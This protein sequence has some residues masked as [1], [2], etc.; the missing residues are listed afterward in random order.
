MR[1]AA[2][3]IAS[4]SGS[5]GVRSS[6]AANPAK[7]APSAPMRSMAAVGTSLA[8]CTP[9][10]SLN[11]T[12]KYLMPFCSAIFDK[13]VTR[14]LLVESG[15]SSV[16]LRSRE[17]FDRFADEALVLGVLVGV[18][19]AMAPGRGNGPQARP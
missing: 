11:E 15:S 17:L 8:R 7:P 2:S 19:G 4:T 12:R 1:L 3:A 16:R 14:G 5:A 6:Q 18:A 9:R 10:R 13:L